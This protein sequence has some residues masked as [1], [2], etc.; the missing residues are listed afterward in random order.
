[1]STK[2]KE[3]ANYSR[4]DF[5]KISGIAATVPLVVTPTVAEAKG[6]QAGIVGPGAVPM[7][8]NVNGKSFSADLEPASLSSTPC[9]STSIL[10]AR[11]ESATA[12]NAAPVRY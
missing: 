5:L 3:P 11:S 4:R 7:T 8:L 1:M 10:P 9:A 6:Q 12:A 2:D